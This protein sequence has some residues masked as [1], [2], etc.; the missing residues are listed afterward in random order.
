MKTSPR[1]VVSSAELPTFVIDSLRAATPS[2]RP[3]VEILFDARTRLILG[4]RV[5]ENRV[6]NARRRARRLTR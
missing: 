4:F 1:T 2:A 5:A 6:A 3:R